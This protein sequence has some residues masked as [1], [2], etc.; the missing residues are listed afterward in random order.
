MADSALAQ[1]ANRSV[2]CPPRLSVLWSIALAGCAAAAAVSIISYDIDEV[3]PVADAVLVAWIVLAYV[4]CGLIAWSRR[5]GSRFGPLMVIAGF[6]PLLSRL[7]EVDPSVLQTIGEVC[8][9]LPVVLFLHVFLAYPS[10]RL[11]R[12]AE[13]RV[14]AAGYS[15]VVGFGVAAMM[16]GPTGRE[17]AIQV[18]SRPHAADVVIAIGRVGVGVVALTALGLL[19]SRARSSRRTLSR[20]FVRICLALALVTVGIGVVARAFEWHGA[21]PI[22]LAAF[23]LIGLAPVLFLVGFLRAHLARS[24]VA[25]LFVELR[26]DPAP[27]DLRNALARA[28]RDPSLELVYWLPEFGSY[29]NLDGSAV[30]LDELSAGRAVTL[31]DRAGSHVAALLH[32]P[33]L[34]DEPELLDAVTAAAALS[35]ENGQLHAELRAR[36]EELRGSRAR[37]VEAGQRE[38]QR[39]ER[40]L[41]DGAQQRLIA[42]ALELSLLETE[43]EGDTN[44]RSRLGQARR[45]IT[46]SLEE[47]REVARG[48]HPAVVSGH[49]LEIALQ[50]LVARAVIPVRLKVE[51]DGRLSEPLEVAAFYLVSES[52]ANV[53]KHANATSASVEVARTNGHI[54]VEVTDDG[55]GGAD[56]ER[57]SGLRG[58]ADRVEALEGRLRIWSPKN[59]G[60]RLRAEIPCAS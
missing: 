15:T 20:S 39:L 17:S 58:L 59:G 8:R 25:D 53:G 24:A 23:T 46:T 41:H 30:E 22:K 11:T 35:L 52:L 34:K 44:A 48:I 13:R 40:N 55:I 36:L 56:T 9:L 50:Q 54:V 18:V 51:V 43:L 2:S 16:L 38:R 19:A 10:G 1:Q 47:L 57:G 33:G 14:V 31:I 32:E 42:L 5:P 12:R 29:A 27:A 26:A 37:I 7:S 3:A 21:E 4:A 6:G 49:G 45:E 28:L 60:T